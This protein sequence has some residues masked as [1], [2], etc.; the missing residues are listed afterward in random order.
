M[1][2][3]DGW[4]VYLT[5]DARVIAHNESTHQ[6]EIQTVEEARGGLPRFRK[7]HEEIG[8]PEPEDI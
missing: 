8:P 2:Q 4:N 3:T 5:D 6:A 7:L 1:E